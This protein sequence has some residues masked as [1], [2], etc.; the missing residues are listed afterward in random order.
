MPPVPDDTPVQLPLAP[1]ELWTLHHVLLDRLESERRSPTTVEPPPIEVF[2]A[3]EKIEAGESDFTA[4]EVR[5][6]RAE[7]RRYVAGPAGPPPDRAVAE[8]VI[9]RITTALARRGSSQPS[10]SPDGR[11]FPR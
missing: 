10:L 11:T 8:R 6:V 2:D 9:D 5:F 1:D 4:R 3:F 7:L